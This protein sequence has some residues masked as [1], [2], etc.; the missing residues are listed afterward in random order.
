MEESELR[1]EDIFLIDTRK[2][3][4]GNLNLSQS[5]DSSYGEKPLGSTPIKTI[6]ETV[7]LNLSNIEMVELMNSES[8]SQNSPQETKISKTE[9]IEILRKAE[10]YTSAACDSIEK[11]L[12]RLI[13]IYS[14]CLCPLFHRLILAIDIL[15]IDTIAGYF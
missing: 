1:P 5:S 7:P 14:L 2:F 11:L 9:A 8:L 3:S 4:D 6:P 15:Y 13:I 12:G 10:N